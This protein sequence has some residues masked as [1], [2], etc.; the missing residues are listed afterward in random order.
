MTANYRWMGTGLIAASYIFSA[1]ASAHVISEEDHHA[2][3]HKYADI[4]VNKEKKNPS[5]VITSDDSAITKLCECIAKE[6]SKHITI[7][8]VKKF[9]RENKYPVSLMM[10]AGQAEYICSQ[11]K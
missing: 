10:K 8:E 6:E 7:D 2:F 11:S 4:C 5:R 3:E 1:N 9:L